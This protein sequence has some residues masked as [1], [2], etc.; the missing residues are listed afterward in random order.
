[1]TVAPTPPA[2]DV[3]LS[4]PRDREGLI[5]RPGLL[6]TLDSLTSN[7]L[8]LVS[9]PAGYG[10]TSLLATWAKSSAA[11]TV[12]WLTLEQRDDDPVRFLAHVAQAI[13]YVRPGVGARAGTILRTRGPDP[14]LALHE[15][16][17]DLA[18]AAP[19]AIVLDDVHLIEDPTCLSLLEYA[20]EHLPQGMHVVAG[21]RV[22]PP[23]PLGRFR[24][25][26]LLGEVRAHDLAFTVAE[27][28]E[29][30]VEVEGLD[31][32][33][34]EVARLHERTEG[35]PVALYLAG[36]WLRGEDNPR[37][38]ARE[39]AANQ[40]YV[41]EYLTEEI[42]A[43]LDPDIRTFLVR[44]SVFDHFCAS[45]CDEVLQR[46]DSHALL[47]ETVLTNLLLVPLDEAGEWFRFHHLF[48]ELLTLE[49]TRT[50]PDLAPQLHRRAAVW[51]QAHDH[52]E[53]A[54]EHALRSGDSHAAV[55]ILSDE[56]YPLLRQ[57][58]G[59][60]LL[61]FVERLPTDVVL[62]HP[63]LAAGSALA[64]HQARRPVHER[65]RWLELVERS[66][67]QSPRTW[68]TRAES[69][70][71]IA[72][73]ISVDGDVG[74]AVKYGR[75]AL[76]LTLEDDDRDGEVP[77]RAALAYALYLCGCAAEAAEHAAKA[78]ASPE[79][80]GRPHSEV[81]ALGMLALLAAD[82]GRVDTAIATADD[83]IQFASTQGFS[84]A[85][86]V[87]LA[88]LGRARALLSKGQLREAEAA[89]ERAERLSRMPDPSVPHAYALLLLAEVRTRR[90]SLTDAARSFDEASREIK[91]FADPGR[92][93][94]IATRVRRRLR[95]ANAIVGARAEPLSSAELAVLR[96]LATDLSQRAIGRR[97]FLSVNTIKTHS[98][99]IY[100]KLG[101]ASR[102][103]AVAR[104]DALGLIVSDD[105]PGVNLAD[106]V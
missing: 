82:D 4:P 29:L 3:K 65:S 2:L 58:D 66:R 83:A 38:R 76:E 43:K 31:L 52:P 12:A 6:A 81:R 45:L 35:W 56:W 41:A 57:G 62:A 96:L 13:E 34:A 73:S 77:A 27:T 32:G 61:R 21:S 75:R 44:A 54:V 5:A 50:E 47:T 60:A 64:T 68:T 104:A 40:R 94:A 9:A 30:L 51:F 71:A 23:L 88:Y 69:A 102:G 59:A 55:E 22:D 39:F 103:D 98:R 24:A 72:R 80:P 100:R 10:K 11:E 7:E 53:D 86:S 93:P 63:E 36:L 42:L 19:L 74:A 85:A 87:H 33:A 70:A 37:L 8:T 91:T 25:R 20:I 78:V 26:A 92:L 89:V 49:L 48:D 90:G 17:E 79:A 28:Y 97:L 67:T 95:A 46:D 99:K 101:V 106:A 1:M 15:L 14:E 18:G 105:S 84:T 16:L